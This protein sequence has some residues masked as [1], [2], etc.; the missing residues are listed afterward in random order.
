MVPNIKSFLRRIRITQVGL[1]EKLGCNQSLIAMWTTGRGYPTFEKIC[2]L[3]ELG[4]SSDELFGKE[5]SDK[6]LQ[7]NG[8]IIDPPAEFNTPAFREGVAMAIAD[9]KS[10]GLL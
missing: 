9:M 3:I 6:L 4:I 5:L 10:K 7:N 2:Q 8:N 1:A